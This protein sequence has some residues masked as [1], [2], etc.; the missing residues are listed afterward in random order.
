MI[1]IA[2]DEQGDFENFY[3]KGKSREF[4]FIGGVIYNDKGDGSDSNDERRRINRYLKC[5][6]EEVGAS[7]P[8][9]LHVNNTG[10]G[11]LV[12]KVKRRIT[13]TLSGF[14][15]KGV[16]PDNKTDSVKSLQAQPKRRGEYHIFA[17]VKRAE[18][19]NA[20]IN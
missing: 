10:N 3:K 4:V 18:G 15:S 7:Y 19:R 6:C 5:V 1:T 11:R 20:F 2:L 16:Y 14:L 8:R 17:M 12:G 13:E 9:D